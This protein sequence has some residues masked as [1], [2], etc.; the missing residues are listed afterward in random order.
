V[1]H[2]SVGSRVVL[3]WSGAKRL[4]VTLSDLVRRY[5]QA[6]AEANSAVPRIQ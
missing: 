3:N 5:E 4:A 2:F 6:M 1:T